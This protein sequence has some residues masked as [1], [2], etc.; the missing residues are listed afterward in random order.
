MCSS[1]LVAASSSQINL[2]W[3]DNSNNESGFK[4][5]RSTDG[6]ANYA[7]IFTTGANATSY[8]NT[9]LSPATPYTYR[10]RAYNLSGNSAYSAAAS[11]T[12]LPNAPVAPDGLTATAASSSQINLSWTDNNSN[13]DGTRIERSIDGLNFSE[14]ATVG[15]N[16]TTYSD[17]KSTRLNSS[18]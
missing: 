12:T 3:A 8:S 13:E 15:A 5:E 16:V 7:E 14:I 17:R 18:H 1:D 6:G 9:A 10:V 4:I 2:T 11:A